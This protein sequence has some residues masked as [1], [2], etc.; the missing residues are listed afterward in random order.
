MNSHLM[1][2]IVSLLAMEVGLYIPEVEWYHDI[3]FCHSCSLL[4]LP[5]QTCDTNLTKYFLVDVVS[6]AYFLT[7]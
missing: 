3:Y 2:S 7:E 4:Y 6:S 1:I 5:T